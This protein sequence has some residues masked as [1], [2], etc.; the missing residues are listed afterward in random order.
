MGCGASKS[1]PAVAE[2]QQVPTKE[3]SKIESEPTKTVEPPKPVEEKPAPPCD[4]KPPE[5]AATATIEAPQPTKVEVSE[6]PKAA[7][8]PPKAEAT[9]KVEEKPKSTPPVEETPPPKVEP[10]TP[11]AT[12]SAAPAA[13]EYAAP[14]DPSPPT[15]EPTAPAMPAPAANQEASSEI[16]VSIN[17]EEKD[18]EALLNVKIS[19]PF[20][21]EAPQKPPLVSMNT[22]YAASKLQSTYRGT[23]DRK[24]VDDIKKSKA[25]AAYE[26]R[27]NAAAADIQ[28]AFKLY[29]NDSTAPAA[30]NEAV[31]EVAPVGASAPKYFEV[32]ITPQEGND[33]HPV[34]V[35]LIELQ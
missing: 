22:D 21:E 27:A 34:K 12:Y 10:V 1:P 11:A 5:A 25:D 17:L 28:A 2:P 18:G 30:S 20:E 15:V 6:P 35:S 29:E 24:K 8:E 32:R 14:A 31:S 13:T 33:S 3:V 19:T 26:E 9:E 4:T 16:V 23:T 7:P